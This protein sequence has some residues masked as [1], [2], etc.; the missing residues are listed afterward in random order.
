MFF[1]FYQTKLVTLSGVLKGNRVKITN[2]RATVNNN[3]SFLY[4]FIHCS[5][6]RNGKDHKK[7]YKSGDLPVLIDDAFAV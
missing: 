1:I 4:V 7:C 6:S 5:L 3:Q 2:C